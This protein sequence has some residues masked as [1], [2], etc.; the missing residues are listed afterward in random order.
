MRSFKIEEQF[1]VNVLEFFE[2]IY[3]DSTFKL[4]FLKQR[5]DQG[6]YSFKL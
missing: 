5:G 2:L 4:N 1:S 6:F 3:K